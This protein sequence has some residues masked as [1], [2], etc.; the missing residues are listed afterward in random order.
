MFNGS[1]IGLV[2]KDG[3]EF[4][5]YEVR[6]RGKRLGGLVMVQEIFGLNDDMKRAADR[7]ASRGYH[8]L[9]PSMF[10]RQ[11]PGFASMDHS[12]EGIAKAGGLARANGIENAMM[13][14]TACFNALKD[15]GPVFVTGFCYGGSMAWLSA[16]NISGFKAA[17]AY[18]GSLLASTK[19]Q[20]AKCPVIAHFGRHDP[21][22][23]VSDGEAFAAANPQVPVFLYDAGHG[24]AREGSHDYDAA[25]DKLALERTLALFEANR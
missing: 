20:K 23:P 14:I 7:F 15:D 25:S 21:H 1:I 5:A 22:I 10:D 16:C 8:V 11:E 12:A 3:F 4:A 18:Y 2:A 13:D 17:S 24:F 9:A 19:D 6:P